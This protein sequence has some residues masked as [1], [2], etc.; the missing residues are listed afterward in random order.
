MDL[1]RR[2]LLLNA[3][4]LFDILNAGFCLI[5]SIF[6]VSD[7]RITISLH[8]IAELKVTINNIIFFLLSLLIWQ[9]IFSY[10]NL[11]QSKRLD[12]PTKE[13]FDVI[14]A[15]SVGCLLI[16]IEAKLFS[17]DV[18]TS[19]TFIV[20]ILFSTIIGVSSRIILRQFLRVVRVRG[21]NL[22]HMLIIGTNPRAIN[23]AEKIAAAPYLGYQI[24]GFV[25]NQWFGGKNNIL[26]RKSLVCDLDNFE[27]FIRNSVVDEVIIAL[28][29]KSLYDQA[30]KIITTC[31]EQG[32]NIR[33][34]SSLFDVKAQDSGKYILDDDLLIHITHQK[35]SL[36]PTFFKK[37]MD[38]MLSL[39]VLI[40]LF[41][42]FPIV[43]IAI[44]I[45]SPGPVIYSQKRIGKGKRI[46][47]LYKFRTM[48]K[49]AEKKQA[50][51]ESIN[52]AK[53]PVFKIENDP[54]ITPI[55]KYLRKTSIDELPQLI[56]VLK[57]EM[58]IVGPR[59]L[60]VRDYKGF[61]EDWHRRRFSVR[62]GITCLW[63]INGRSS[64]PFERWMELDMEYID[65][66]S[67]WLDL[68]IILK[69][70]P[71]VLKGAGAF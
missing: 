44:K 3:F 51:L 27:A 18:I 52:E 26:K 5:I 20:F 61:R 56:N 69:T 23:F 24:I 49:N 25:D 47:K 43:S 64:V 65:Q 17:V 53:G 63:Q 67:L 14:Q 15:S 59:P 33:Y 12:K 4:K 39:I 31:E 2:K 42:L 45:D 8:Q 50:D 46:F 41:P 34:L 66:W 62:P 6:W 71:I 40:L 1:L 60:P 7:N 10:F 21:R 35:M 58:S 13:I 19:Y 32:I 68:K 70:I 16:F 38:I 37:T 29:I 55:G 57:G 30:S 36:Y 22:R 54:R 48:Y 9:I 28:P 11:Y